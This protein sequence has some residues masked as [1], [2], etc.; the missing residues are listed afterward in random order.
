MT[1]KVGNKVR[2]PK[3]DITYSSVWCDGCEVF[4][5]III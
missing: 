3:L 2:R 4:I 5:F 1:G